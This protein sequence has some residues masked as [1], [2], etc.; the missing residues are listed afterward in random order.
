[1]TDPVEPEPKRVRQKPGPKPEILTA[2]QK[3]DILAVLSDG[4]SIFGAAKYIG[5]SRDFLYDTWKRDPQFKQECDHAIGSFE[6][7]MITQIEDASVNDRKNLKVLLEI[8]ER[9]FPLSWSTRPEMRK[10]F[11]QMT[12]EEGQEAKPDAW[13]QKEDYSE[14]VTAIIAAREALK[15]LNENKE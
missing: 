15:K 7:R 4:V 13:I 12:E 1:M 8:M 11:G 10:D 5:R 2:K 6:R 9:R 14:A 3:A